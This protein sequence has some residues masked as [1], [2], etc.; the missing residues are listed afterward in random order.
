[1]TTYKNK[2]EDK[3]NKKKLIDEKLKI[4][5]ETIGVE[6][7]DNYSKFEENSK[8]VFNVSTTKYFVVRFVAK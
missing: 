8:L 6:D 7:N 2:Q 3:K 1:M 5:A 4:F